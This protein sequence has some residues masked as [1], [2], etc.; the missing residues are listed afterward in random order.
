MHKIEING[1]KLEVY[2]SIDELPI[3]RFHAF[4]RYLLID[5]GVGSDLSDFDSHIIALLKFLERSDV[6]NAK[7]EVMNL[8]QNVAFAY[9]Q[10]SPKL[11]AFVPLIR[12]INGKPLDDLSEE[13][14]TEVL[15]MLSD[16]GVTAGTVSRWVEEAKKKLKR[17]LIYFFQILPKIRA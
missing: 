17:S 8:R 10:Q 12:S 13:T 14:V 1:H 5:A 11:N 16:N 9:D 4:N 7:K 6:E 15:R 3:T 2:D